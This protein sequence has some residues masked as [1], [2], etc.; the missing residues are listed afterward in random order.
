MTII[1][2][3]EDLNKRVFVCHK[4]AS[5]GGALVMMCEKD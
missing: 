3:K 2:N 1:D 4:L 5:D